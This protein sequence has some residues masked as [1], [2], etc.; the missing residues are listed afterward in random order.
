MMQTAFVSSTRRLT[1]V[2]LRRTAARRPRRR[3]FVKFPAGDAA[4]LFT[5]LDAMIDAAAVEV[6][7]WLNGD[8]RRVLESQ[9]RA[10]G[11]SRRV[12]QAGLSETLSGLLAKLGE[13][14]RG[15]FSDRKV[16]NLASLLVQRIV[17]RAG[18]DVSK[19]VERV[20]S[21]A[22]IV[23]PA[24]TTSLRAYSEA[25]IAETVAFIKTVPARLLDRITKAIHSAATLGTPWTDVVDEIRGFADVTRSEAKRVAVTELS[26][27]YN[28]A[29]RMRYEEFGVRHA[30]WLTAHDE[31]VCEICGPLDG[32]RFT[33]EKLQR[34]GWPPRHPNCR[35]TTVADQGELLRMIGVE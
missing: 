4:V 34:E 16:N 14:V 10:I 35:C 31:R 26:K 28:G 8:I 21:G 12:R 24:T 18:K 19:D 27:T 15:I 17:S 13:R 25:R 5:A 33:L 6:E 23:D 32:K 30:E 1:V 20:T 11:M 3:S 29:T 9:A 22:I 2:R 7:R